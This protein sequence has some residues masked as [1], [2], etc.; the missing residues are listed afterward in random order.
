MGRS[1]EAMS[2]AVLI[3]GTTVA[4]NEASQI[5]EIK[6]WLSSHDIVVPKILWFVDRETGDTLDRPGFLKLQTAIF[7]G[8][9][10]TVVVWKLDR[11]SRSLRD[12][13]NVLA[14]WLDRG[15]RLVSV[16]Q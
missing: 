12:G 15:V 5:R 1:L 3:R 14:D 11:L 13:I 7:H 2:T 16:T 4:Q 9:V 8:E 10:K 6:R